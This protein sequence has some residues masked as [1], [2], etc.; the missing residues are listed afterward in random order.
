MHIA[1]RSIFLLGIYWC[2][3]IILAHNDVLNGPEELRDTNAAGAHRVNVK[4]EQTWLDKVSQ[5]ACA[6]ATERLATRIRSGFASVVRSISR[7]ERQQK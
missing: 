5:T 7:T 4:L 1:Q 3:R 6:C 2:N